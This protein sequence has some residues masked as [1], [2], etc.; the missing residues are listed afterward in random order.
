MTS[1]IPI[2]LYF[3][4]GCSVQFAFSPPPILNLAAAS[5]P[6]VHF[7]V[8][9]IIYH[10]L[11]DYGGAYEAT[12][13]QYTQTFSTEGKRMMRDFVVNPIPYYYGLITYNGSTITVS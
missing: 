8:G 2:S 4:N 9:T 7:D 1:S 5:S 13:T 10:D 3:E 12:P 11:D 6:N